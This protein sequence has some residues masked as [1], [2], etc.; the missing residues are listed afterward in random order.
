MESIIKVLKGK[1]RLIIT[2]TLA[3]AV[4]AG[5]L[6][7]VQPLQYSASIRLLLT[8]KASFTLDPYTAIRSTEL[9]GERLVQVVETSSFL[10]RMLETGYQIDKE[11]FSISEDKRR[12]LWNRTIDASLVRGTGLFKITAYHSSK[13][14][15]LKIVAATAFLLS[16][17]GSDYIGRDIVVRLVDAPLASRFPTRPNIP[18]N[19]IVGAIIGFVLSSSWVY[20]DH[21]KKKHHGHLL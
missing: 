13:E 5:A 18:L 15:A 8:Q 4:L 16:T 17:Q 20:I 9:I 3:V 6:S 21:R 19:I 11:Y 2:S 10:S 7:F 12:K 14:E 1:K